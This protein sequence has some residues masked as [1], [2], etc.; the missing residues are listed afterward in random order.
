M[1]RDVMIKILAAKTFDEKGSN[2]LLNLL[3]IITSYSTPGEFPKLLL[4]KAVKYFNESRKFAAS[5]GISSITLRK[6]VVGIKSNKEFDEEEYIDLAKEIRN[7][8]RKANTQVQIPIETVKFLKAYYAWFKRDSENALR[9]IIKHISAAGDND[10]AKVFSETEV[11][12]MPTK[13]SQVDAER[14]ATNIVKQKLGMNKPILDMENRVKLK[15]KNP[16]A[17]KEYLRARKAFN[18]VPKAFL[19]QYVR[20]NSKEGKV[21]YKTFIAA[22]EK[23]GIK[24]TYAKGF[25]GLI[26]DVG[27]IYTTAGLKIKAGITQPG[28]KIIMNPKYDPKQDNAYVFVIIQP[29]GNKGQM[30]T[31]KYREQ[32]KDVQFKKTGELDNKIDSVMKKVKSNLTNN[33]PLAKKC[34]TIVNLAWETL[35]RVGNE[36]NKTD[37][38]ETIGLTTLRVGHLTKQGNKVKIEFSGKSGVP[39]KYV[40]A[41]VD[42][43]MKATIENLLEFSEGKDK[44]DYVFSSEKNPNKPIRSTV[45]NR[46]F[47]LCG[48]N[49]TIKYVRTLKG[50]RLARQLLEKAPFKKGAD[51]KQGEVEKWYKSEMEAVG[52]ILNHKRGIGSSEKITGATAIGSY[53]DIN[54]QRQ[55]F[56]KLGLRI[57][58]FLAKVK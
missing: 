28:V 50:T 57:P 21:D 4:P 3:G 16:A 30:Y 58:T 54:L 15:A 10:V 27:K 43:F 39:A 20:K 18:E 26:D 52:K 37:G 12:E 47:K 8:V 2:A 17:Y 19:Q 48:A 55:F 1:G 32:K 36:G 53:I 9:Y 25:D 11:S 31:Y 24:H 46:F 35:A 42:R 49:T 6:A 13:E 40:I 14:K 45:V 38:V 5:L 33:N 23:E 22:L 7:G 41:P 44:K 34:A 29:N 51:L 56:A